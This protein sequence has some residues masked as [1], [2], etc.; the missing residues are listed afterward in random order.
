MCASRY[1]PESQ[2]ESEGWIDWFSAFLNPS[3]EAFEP[4]VD[5]YYPIIDDISHVDVSKGNN[6]TTNS[7]AIVGAIAIQFYWREFIRDILPPGSN[8]LV[9]V[10]QS[11]CN[12]PFTYQIN[13]PNVK[14][15]GVLD[16]HD[17]KYDH[18]L[19]ESKIVDLNSFALR[20]RVYTGAP[21]NQNICP[22]TV[23]IYPSDVMKSQFTSQNGLIALIS[24]LLIFAFTSLVFLVYDCS[25]E[26]RQGQ[27][28]E[29]AIRSSGIVDSLFPSTVRN[30]LY[31]AQAQK[32]K[33]RKEA[34]SVHAGEPH[35]SAID[36]NATN[37][38][39]SLLSQVLNQGSIAQVYPDTTVIFADITV[40][41]GYTC[42][43]DP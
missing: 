21:I 7:T 29:S 30:Q 32:Q 36:E 6:F 33:Y 19:I 8:G 11:P 27:V 25:V 17:S 26:R 15:L 10:I 37:N 1:D 24:L 16:N 12:L 23:R 20:S 18:L 40:V 3:E 28:L 38:S 42:A 13:G 41:S 31:D 14:Y 34:V 39:S 22:Y 2:A 35:F 5:V 43:I 4:V 9:V